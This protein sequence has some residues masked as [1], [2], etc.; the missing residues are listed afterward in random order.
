MKTTIFNIIVFVLMTMAMVA[1]CFSAGAA[2]NL[3]TL[4][5]IWLAG[6]VISFIGTFIFIDQASKEQNQRELEYV[7]SLKNNKNS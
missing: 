1:Y 4:A 2:A 6:S 5:L 7:E 3:G